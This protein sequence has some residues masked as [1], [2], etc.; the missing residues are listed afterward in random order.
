M[1]FRQGEA[2]QVVAE[3]QRALQAGL[4]IRRHAVAGQCRHVRAELATRAAIT[5]AGQR[6]ADGGV[7][8]AQCGICIGHQPQHRL[9]EA[10][11]VA[12][13]RADAAAPGD[14]QRRIARH[15]LDLGAADVDAV[16]GVGDQLSH[17]GW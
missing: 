3:V 16:G 7:V 2:L 13:R 14:L 5:H 8:A 4:Q 15:Q 10:F 1:C 11:I 17:G 9:Q 6:D 12:L